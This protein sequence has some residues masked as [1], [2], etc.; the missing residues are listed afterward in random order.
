MHVCKAC[1]L[2]SIHLPWSMGTSSC[3]DFMKLKR[4]VSIL[5]QIKLIFLLLAFKCFN[6]RVC[7]AAIN[8]G[9]T[10]SKL[11]NWQSIICEHCDCRIVISPIYIQVSSDKKTGYTGKLT[12]MYFRQNQY[13]YINRFK[14]SIYTLHNRD[15]KC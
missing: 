12:Q 11:Y 14:L 6:N 8:S 13:K 1:F 5:H 7:K 9:T 3:K 15:E 10:S 4:L 2:R